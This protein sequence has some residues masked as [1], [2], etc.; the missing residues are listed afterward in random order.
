MNKTVLITGTTS[1]IGEA[2]CRVFAAKGH[3]LILVARNE[4]ALQAQADDL[5]SKG[6]KIVTICQ[7]LALPGAAQNV[8][9]AVVSQGLHVDIL[10]NNA[11]FNVAGDFAGTRLKKE[12]EMQ[13]VHIQILTE[14]T[15]CFL[16]AMLRRG[17]GRLLNLGSIASYIPCPSDAVYA[18]TKAYILSFSSALH[19]ELKGTGVTVTCI[20]PGATETQFAVK[21]HIEDSL[22]FTHMVMDPLRVAQLGYKGLML[23]RRTV[24]PG[25]H[26]RFLVA[27][28]HFFPAS[29]ITPIAAKLLRPSVAD[30]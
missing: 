4:A 17:F 8:F 10:V 3:P 5:R 24:I 6:G 13:R 14:L 19:Q 16:P 26:N 29:F 1:G 7:D 23:G 22:L 27:A 9:D 2:F 15:K 11:G 20:C 25:L 21:S 12:L 18:A 30:E 28:S